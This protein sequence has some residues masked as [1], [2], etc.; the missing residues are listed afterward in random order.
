MNRTSINPAND[1]TATFNWIIESVTITRKNDI[2]D[3]H[4]LYRNRFKLIIRAWNCT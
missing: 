3:W 2:K 1:M 4:F